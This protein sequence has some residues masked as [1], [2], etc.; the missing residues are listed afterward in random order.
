MDGTKID[1]A[2]MCMLKGLKILEDL[3]TKPGWAV[4]CFG[5]CELYLKGGRI[6]KGLEALRKAEQMFKEMGM[7]YWLKKTEEVWERV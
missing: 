4:G 5:L 2:E 7:A 6:E 1:E 3:E